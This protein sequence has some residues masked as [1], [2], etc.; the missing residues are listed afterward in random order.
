MH[1]AIHH[2]LQPLHVSDAIGVDLCRLSSYLV[3]DPRQVFAH[4]N[5]SLSRPPASDAP[6]PPLFERFLAAHQMTRR[7]IVGCAFILC[8]HPVQEALDRKRGDQLSTQ[9]AQRVVGLHVTGVEAVHNGCQ[10]MFGLYK[11]DQV[12]G[13]AAAPAVS[14]SNL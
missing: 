9:Q 10:W 5:L 3:F 4:P 8:I 6:P 2:A 7:S 14:I 13:P 1:A 12:C 11:L